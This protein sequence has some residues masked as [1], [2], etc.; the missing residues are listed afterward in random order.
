HYLRFLKARMD[1]MHK[2][3]YAKGH[4]LVNGYAPLHKAEDI[5]KYIKL[6]RYRCAYLTSYLPELNPITFSSLQY[7]IAALGQQLLSLFDVLSIERR[8]AYLLDNSLRVSVSPNSITV[9]QQSTLCSMENQEMTSLAFIS[10]KIICL[11]NKKLC[12]VASVNVVDGSFLKE[13]IL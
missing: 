7:F 8:F 2:Y 4:Y 1:Q 12:E 9:P 10:G 3:P 6:R 13:D 11:I 5:S